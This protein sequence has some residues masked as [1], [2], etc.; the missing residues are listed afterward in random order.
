MVFASLSLVL[1]FLGDLQ[2]TIFVVYYLLLRVAYHF[3]THSNRHE[4]LI[5]LKRLIECV[6]LFAFF[7]A[8]FLINFTV[9]QNVGG[10]SAGLHSQYYFDSPS[11]YIL[12]GAGT[13]ISTITETVNFSKY[14]GISLLALSFTP[15]LFSKFQMKF[16]RQNYLFHWLTCGF[17][18]LIAM[19][20]PLSTLVTTLFVRAPNRVQILIIFSV[21]I[22]A[23]YGL[24]C[25][26]NFLKQKLKGNTFYK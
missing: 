14:L 8:P 23:G 9:L 2:I 18:I 24:L 5:L 26:N 11:Q 16:N 4:N 25:L 1:L 17:F 6:A 13:D 21:C 10:L 22:C 3:I 15:L 20:T 12:R 7:V 19:G